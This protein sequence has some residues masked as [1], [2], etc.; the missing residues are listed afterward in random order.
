MRYAVVLIA[1][2]L[3][4]CQTVVQNQDG[5]TEI[6]TFG[7]GTVRISEEDGIETESPGISEGLT[8]VLLELPEAALRVLGGM[9]G[10]LASAPRNA[11]GSAQCPQ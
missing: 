11:Q 3:C 4:A 7:A 5:S 1:C 10:G 8:R 2:L 9:A 6:R